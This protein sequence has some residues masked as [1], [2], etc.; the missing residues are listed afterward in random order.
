MIHLGSTKEPRLTVVLFVCE[1]LALDIAVELYQ[2]VSVS[3]YLTRV[4]VLMET[5]HEYIY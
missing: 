4:V 3:W 2:D 5:T 1:C